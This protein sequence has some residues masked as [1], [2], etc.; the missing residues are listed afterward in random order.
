MMIADRTVWNRILSSIFIYIGEWRKS[1]KRNNYITLTFPFSGFHEEHKE[2]LWWHADNRLNKYD[3]FKA[4][5]NKRDFSLGHLPWKQRKYSCLF[6]HV[7]SVDNQCEDKRKETNNKIKLLRIIFDSFQ[8]LSVALK[9]F[10]G[11]SEVFQTV[12]ILYVLKG[13]F[14]LNGNNTRLQSRFGC[15]WTVVANIDRGNPLATFE[16]SIHVGF[17]PHIKICHEIC[18]TPPVCEVLNNPEASYS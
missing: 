5:P 8:K 3:H 17:F 11:V 13:V 15:Q 7:V 6:R 1:S 10:T 9:F 2:M 14:P 4:T 12:C 18:Q 16:Y